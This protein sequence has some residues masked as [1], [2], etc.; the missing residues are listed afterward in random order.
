MALADFDAFR[1]MINSPGWTQHIARSLSAG[2]VTAFGSG[3]TRSS[4]PVPGSTPSATAALSNADTGAMTHPASSGRLCITSAYVG[5]GDTGANSEGWDT[6]TGGLLI[7]R[8]VHGGLVANI[9]TTQDS[10]S[11]PTKF[12]TAA[13]TR[14]TS[15]EGV[16]MALE[17]YTAMGATDTVYTFS[18]TNQAG[19]SGQ[20]TTLGMSG[21]PAADQFW[22]IPLAAGDTGVRSVESVSLTPSTGTA[23]NFGITLFKPIAIIPSTVD[24]ATANEIV[25]WNTGIH[26]DAHLQLLPA[27]PNVGSAGVVAGFVSMTDVA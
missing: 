17:V 16:F 14:Y 4:F 24:M 25:G 19:T 20:T 12:P 11:D 5:H 9:T 10:T 26:S 7:D 1:A 13:L 2:T 15:G 18:Y 3:W 27:F 8:L 22:P 21:N 6:V 23:G